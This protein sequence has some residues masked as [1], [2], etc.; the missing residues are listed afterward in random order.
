MKRYLFTALVSAAVS[1]ATGLVIYFAF[2]NSSSRGIG[3]PATVHTYS[4]IRSSG[5]IRAAY[6]VGAPLFEIDPNT[7]QKSGIFYDITN[8]AA[9]HLGLRVE[10]TEEVGYGQMI[11]GL[12]DRRYDI[13]GSGVWINADRGKSAD[14]T[15]A[16]YYDAVYVYARNGDTRFK[17]ISNINSPSFTISTMDGELGAAIAKADFPRARTLEL[18]QNADF[19]QMILNVVSGKADVVFLAAAPARAYQVA[20]PGKIMVTEPNRPVAG[21]LLFRVPEEAN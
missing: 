2:F 19:A 18:P 13:V 4:Q 16:A 17:D 5:T 3:T 20:N 6:A 1:A 21:E 12:S 11:Q 14:F 8:A 7:S 9:K 15:N 10:W